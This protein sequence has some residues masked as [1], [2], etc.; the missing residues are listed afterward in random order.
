VRDHAGGR[1]RPKLPSIK[2]GKALRFDEAAVE[3]WLEE[4]AKSSEEKG[5]A[6]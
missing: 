3:H 2:L 6:A 1:R 5:R 4:M